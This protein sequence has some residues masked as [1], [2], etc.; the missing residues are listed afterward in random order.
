MSSNNTRYLSYLSRRFPSA[1][2]VAIE[3]VHN[4]GKLA[5][6][7]PSELYISDIHGEYEAFAN[8]LRTGCGSLQKIIDEAFGDSLTVQEKAALTCLICYPQEKMECI[9]NDEVSCDAWCENT[10]SQLLVLFDYV[11]LTHLDEDIANS[12]DSKFKVLLEDM[13]LQD[14]PTELVGSLI[15]HN[16][17]PN[18]IE[19]LCISLRT[20]LVGKLHMVGDVYDRGPYPDLI[21]DELVSCPNIDIQWGNHDIVWMGAALGQ[22]G[23]IAHVVRNCARYGNL[24]ILTDAYGINILPLANFALSAYKDDPCVGYGLKGNPNLSPE[25]LDLNIKIQKAMAILQFK[26]E[27]RHIDDNPSF[28]LESR[29]LLHTINLRTNTVCIDGINYDVVDPVFPTVNWTDPYKL[30]DEEEAVMTSLE[31][32]FIHCEKLQRHIL[33]LL[34]KGS[35]YKIENNTLMF[36]AC[37]PLNEDGSLKEVNIYGN[38][39]KG[40]ALF[41]AVDKYVRDAFTAKDPEARKKGCDLLWYLWLGEGSPLFA[42]SKMATF[43]IYLIAE[44][45][46]RKEVKNSFYSLLENKNVLN[47]IFE[48][49]GMD[50]SNA[51]IVCGHTPVKVKDGEDPVKC[52]GKVIIIDGGMSSA[53]QSTTGIAGF[54]LVSDAEGLRL[55]S[56]KPFVGTTSAIQLDKSV[57]STERILVKADHLIQVAE[58]DKGKEIKAYLADLED[59]LHYY[60]S[61]KV[62]Q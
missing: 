34:E 45:A 10:I 24:S 56:H 54:T 20:L 13:L 61:S 30:T 12:L 16:I 26:V 46:A 5:L 11:S 62:S 52:G 18:F 37:V 51:R 33:L 36:H 17:A 31:Q 55:A 38:T 15:N 42:K 43:E 22:R 14:Y 23:C 2:D 8:I 44:K 57:S 28:N 7:K 21:M 47:G 6:P 9:L 29:K 39:Y 25:E 27:A 19:A 32:A 48:D 59:L 60:T 1:Q 35:L 40:K 50:P 41:D 3:I 49:F 53:Y 58:T 4:T